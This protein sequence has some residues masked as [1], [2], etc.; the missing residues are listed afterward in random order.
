MLKKN[1]VNKS[2]SAYDS[3]LDRARALSQS[4]AD[5]SPDEE[6][7]A[8]DSVFQAAANSVQQGQA[9][10]QISSLNSTAHEPEQASRGQKM[11]VAQIQISSLSSTAHEPEQIQNFNVWTKE[12]W[13]QWYRDSRQK[14][15]WKGW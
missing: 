11:S 9:Q 5:N 7:Q 13:D 14:P 4:M 10:I 12:E 15:T 3:L 2:K 6:D 1:K 8:Q